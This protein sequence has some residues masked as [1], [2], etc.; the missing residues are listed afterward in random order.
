MMKKLLL[1]LLLLPQLAFGAITYIGVGTAADGTNGQSLSP[2]LH[3]S[4]ASGDLVLCLA[5]QKSGQGAVA[6][7]ASG[8]TAIKTDTSSRADLTLFAK[9]AGGAEGSPTIVYGDA[10]AG[11]G[12]IAQCATFR[13]TL[14]DLADIVAHS[15]ETDNGAQQDVNTPALTI[16]TPNTLVLVIGAKENDWEGADVPTLSGFTEIAQP[17]RSSTQ[18]SGLVW[19]YVIQ[20]TA[21]NVSSSFFDATAT[22][23]EAI[24]FA[25]SLKPAAAMS[26]VTLTS[27]AANTP[28][29]A[30]N[31]A[32]NPDIAV[33]DVLTAPQ[34]T[35]PG[36]YVLTVGVDCQ[37]SYTGDASRQ[38]ALNVAVFDT[39]V[40]GTHASDI[41]FWVN[42]E[43]PVCDT[44][45]T[46]TLDQSVAM[47]AIDLTA[48]CEDAES[49][50]LTC[51]VAS[52][53]LATGLSLGGTGNCTLSGTPSVESEAGTAVGLSVTDIAGASSTINLTQVVIN[54]LTV[55]NCVNDDVLACIAE[56][57]ALTLGFTLSTECTASVT[58]GNV[59]RTD[60]ASAQEVEPFSD[61][62]IVVGR[63]C[64]S[65][66]GQVQSL[67]MGLSIN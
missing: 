17:E 36:D 53:S 45:L 37:F 66:T 50:S 20:T 52:G 60:P 35:T 38:S 31:T 12:V 9:I 23:N 15:S 49:D 62:E 61:V 3:A 10:T 14:T 33:G 19:D 5:F 48:S 30:F 54:T 7:T 32:V 8:Y 47:T 29:T 2:T 18:Q 22:S 43:T 21:T 63:L 25:I 58:S 46:I 4:T 67:G 24:S 64:R 11:R 39:S 27:I 6:I 56:L 41:D 65:G 34:A 57:E 55:P 42:N 40:G 44:P 16:T 51:A 59:L 26:G 1:A 28:C 13:G